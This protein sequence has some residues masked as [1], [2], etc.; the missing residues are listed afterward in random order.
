MTT[1][2]ARS[3]RVP[4][5]TWRERAI[6]AAA[7]GTPLYGLWEQLDGE[8][9]SASDHLLDEG[10]T[11]GLIDSYFER[12]PGILVIEQLLKALR[13]IVPGPDAVLEVPAGYD[14]CKA[15]AEEV[16]DMASYDVEALLPHVKHPSRREMAEATIVAIDLLAEITGGD[17]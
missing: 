5:R 3:M 1:T 12:R 8:L 9:G 16:S 10:A 2:A 15:L 6:L 13:T 11:D 4:V 7:I 14:V 17:A